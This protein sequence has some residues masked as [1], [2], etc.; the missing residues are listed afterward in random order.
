MIK[1]KIITRC[2]GSCGELIQGI[3]LGGEKLISY[4]IDCYSYVKI[5][6]GFQNNRN[7]YPKAYQALEKAID[8]FGENPKWSQKLRIEIESE[9]PKAKGMAS[10]T[11]DLGAT[12]LAIAIYLKREITPEEMTKICL[13]IEPTDSIL[14]PDL[15]LLDHH[16]GQ[17]R[18]RYQKQINCKVLV[19]EGKQMI[20]TLEFHKINRES[21][22]QKNIPQIHQAMQK[23]EMGIEKENLKDVG[24]G[25]ILSA[26]AN[27]KIL[28]KPGLEM[29]VEKALNLGAYGVNVAH[30]GS[31]VGIIF[32]DQFFDKEN[33]LEKIKKENFY[34]EYNS[35][36]EYQ[37]VQGGPDIWEG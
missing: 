26:F 23:I 19:L 17:Y 27:Q 1:K 37:T 9:L 24:Q 10:S 30:S 34:K 4:P 3:I 33:F 36:K 6:E 2:P 35:I 7:Q 11:A 18:R 15:T 8:Y 5:E 14:F 32:H 20:D 29:I 31:I 16:K 12:L 28:K 22:L 21:I 13:E 25:V